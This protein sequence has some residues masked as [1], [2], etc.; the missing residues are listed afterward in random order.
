MSRSTWAGWTRNGLFNFMAMGMISVKA[1][2]DSVFLAGADKTSALAFGFVFPVLILLNTVFAAVTNAVLSTFARQHWLDDKQID[3]GILWQLSVAVLLFGLVLCLALKHGLGGIVYLLDAYTYQQQLRAFIDALW[4]WIPLQLVATLLICVARGSNL[5]KPSGII[6][7][8]S[9]LIGIVASFTL[10]N[11]YAGEWAPL[12]AIVLSNA[13]GALVMLAWSFA[14]LAKRL[15]FTQLVDR[16][17]FYTQAGKSSVKVLY[18]SFIANLFAMAFIFVLTRK[19]AKQGEPV[20]NAMVYLT[21]FEQLLLILFSALIGAMLPQLSHLVREKQHEMAESYTNEGVK[22]L[23]VIGGCLYLL[24]VLLMWLLPQPD[25]TFTRL[26]MVWFAGTMMQGVSLMYLQVITI[27]VSPKLATKINFVRFIVLGIPLLHI[28]GVYLG[29]YGIVVSLLF[30]Q[31][32]SCLVLVKI[33][34]CNWQL[35]GGYSNLYRL[36]G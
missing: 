2:F 24:F 25:Q 29:A 31:L 19:L 7:S 8:I 22:Y 23:L 12:E 5:F 13:C 14:L 4:L 21:R 33:F 1:I 18:H 20:I 9:Y 34:R 16:S 11:G 27:V 28:S 10:L 3:S 35:K 17:Q 32:I 30:I 26:A 36:K 6:T 15:K